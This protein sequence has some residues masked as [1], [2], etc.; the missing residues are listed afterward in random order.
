MKKVSFKFKPLFFLVLILVLSVGGTIAY[1]TVRREVKNEFQALTY[2]VDMVEEADSTFGKKVVTILNKDTMPVVVRVSYN[3]IWSNG[4]VQLSNVVNGVNVVQKGWSGVWQNDFILGSDGWYYYKKVL[5]ANSSINLIN[6]IS[7]NRSL[8][9]SSPYKEDYLHFSYELNFGFE[10]IQA[11][12]EAIK[13][14][15][16]LDVT[17][18]DNAIVWF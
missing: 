13:D 7:L 16:G 14:L 9:D 2:H 15:W 6:S 5:S 8:V 18:N 3:E 4:D 11:T 17:I 1:F 10:A 12:E